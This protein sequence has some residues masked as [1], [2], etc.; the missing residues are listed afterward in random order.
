MAATLEDYYENGIL[1][2]LL[3]KDVN[4]ELVPIYPRSSA[5]LVA[6]GEAGSVADKLKNIDS[7]LSNISTLIND[8]STGL[9][10]V[11]NSKY[12]KNYIDTI[13][14][15]VN[16][17]ILSLKKDTSTALTKLNALNVY[18][19]SEVDALVNNVSTLTT[20]S[21]NSLQKNI[22]TLNTLLINNYYS[23]I[24]MDGINNS[25]RSDME[26]LKVTLSDE[27]AAEVD[28][29][30]TEIEGWVTRQIKEYYNKSD[31]DAMI[32]ATN[33]NLAAVSSSVQSLREES[34]DMNSSSVNQINTHIDENNSTLASSIGERL[35]TTKTNIDSKIDSQTSEIAA[36]LEQVKGAVNTINSSV[37]AQISK[38]HADSET[39]YENADEEEF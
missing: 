24:Q 19:K 30:K 11:D 31:V 26:K 22:D 20:T 7:T 28:D 29:Y 35:D 1:K 5:D 18:D 3:A 16:K 36:M 34:L 15:N 12:D 37:A 4:G 2:S 8:V 38:L 10:N 39:N 32:N 13:I 14:S 21:F 27:L 6:Y 23:S 33:N 17:D 9:S 25:L